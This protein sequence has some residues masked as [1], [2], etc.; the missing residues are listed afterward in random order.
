MFTR[1]ATLHP[2]PGRDALQERLQELLYVEQQTAPVNKGGR[3]F[4]AKK[5]ADQEKAIFYW[6]ND[7]DGE[8]RVLLDPNAMSADG[9]ISVGPVIA[10]RS[11]RYVAYMERPDNA[12]ES[13]LKVMEVDTG[14]VLDDA[15][16]GLRYTTP[17]WTPDDAGFFYTWLPSGISANEKMGHGEVRYHRLGTDPATDEVYRE[18]TGDS[19]RWLAAR[20]TDDGKWLAL[21]I[22]FGWAAHDVYLMRL[23]DKKRR[24]RP[25]AVGLNSRYHVRGH[26]GRLFVATNHEAARWQI[27][28]VNPD[29]L[30]RKHW[31]RIVAED[32]EAVLQSMDIVGG[33]L[34]LRYLK[35]ASSLMQL[36]S[37]DG[38]KVDTVELPGIGTTSAF[39]G[40]P[41]QGDAFFSFSSFNNPGAIYRVD[42]ATGKATLFRQVKAA[43][44]PD[45]FVVEQHR[46]PSKDGTL[47]SMFLI[48]KKGLK[49]NPSTPTVLFGYGGFNISLTPRF[50]AM[51]IPWVEQGGLWAVPNLRGGGEYGETWHRAGML[52]NKQNV[53][54]DFIAAAEWLVAE[55]YTSRPHL[56]IRGRSN[57]GLLVGA[58]ITQRPEL[59]GAV[60]CG[61]P[62]LDMVRYHRFGIGR[63]WI[64]EYGSADDPEQFKWLYAY[65]PYHHVKAQTAYP[66]LLMLSADHDDRVD[67]MHARKFVAAIEHASSSGHPNLLRIET[68]SGHGGSDLRSRSAARSADM[69]A[70]LSAMLR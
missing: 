2:L 10:S 23:G 70:F 51:R 29:R 64:P 17:S 54:D 44:D 53:F 42:V 69:L 26:A 8:A 22:T 16:T 63:A 14:K 6:A 66:P 55:G 15:I 9:S 48:Y 12:D 30:E 47:V 27:F 67:P 37:L 32:D 34:G 41:S 60:V 3:W 58:A 1:A 24:W 13:T 31:K 61:V 36:R 21:T 65:S 25:L 35:R 68:Q 43:L 56:G 18:K 4:F 19:R 7:V 62:L 11:G 38:S 33:R 5:P 45:K 40:K 49:K 52:E 57:G 46:F 39:A 20:V 59:Y 28:E 50:E